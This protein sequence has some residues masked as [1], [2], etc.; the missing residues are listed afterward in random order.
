MNKL[1]LEKIS[2]NHS[3]VSFRFQYV[4]MSLWNRKRECL[5]EV[6]VWHSQHSSPCFHLCAAAGRKRSEVPRNICP[7]PATRYGSSSTPQNNE[8]EEELTNLQRIWTQA[9]WETWGNRTWA[10]TLQE[11]V[12]HTPGSDPESRSVRRS[13][14]RTPGRLPR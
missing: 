5:Y 11:H 10:I 4:R 13:C 7:P 9:L 12:S 2:K 14:S 1:K 3:C 8:W 6:C